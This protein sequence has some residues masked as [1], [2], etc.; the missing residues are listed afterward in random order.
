MPKWWK[1][2]PRPMNRLEKFIMKYLVWNL[3]LIWP[4]P[5]VGYG[6]YYVAMN[7]QEFGLVVLSAMIGIFIAL[8]LSLWQFDVI[9][10]MHNCS[11]CVA[12]SCPKNVVPKEHVDEYLRRNPAMMDAWIESGYK[13]SSPEKGSD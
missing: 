2:S 3:T 8:I 4:I 5:F 11:R 12:F 9:M 13:L 10:R 1:P 6:I 7:Y